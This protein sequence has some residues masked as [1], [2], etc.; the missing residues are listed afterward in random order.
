MPPPDAVQV[1][2]RM[3]GRTLRLSELLADY[4][5]APRIVDGLESLVPKG[6]ATG[7]G[8]LFDA[9]LR[10][11]PRRVSATI[12]LTDNE[13]GRLV[14][15]AESDG[16]VRS[17]TFDLRQVEEE[18]AAV[19]ISLSYEGPSGIAGAVIG[20]VVEETLRARARETLERLRRLSV[21]GSLP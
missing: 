5:L 21:D 18:T 12:E 19:R 7:V 17:I 13:P 20:R 3:P 10:L 4:S 11:G 1:S 2:T 9:V 6:E 16:G 14:R 8:A 15:W